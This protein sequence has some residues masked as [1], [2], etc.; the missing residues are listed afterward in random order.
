M[1]GNGTEVVGSKVDGDDNVLRRRLMA[2]AM[3][4]VKVRCS[5]VAGDGN[6][7]CVYGV[8]CSVH[9]LGQRSMALVM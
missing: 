9:V 8:D 4:C 5:K 3:C 2:T 6:V 1:A 7:C